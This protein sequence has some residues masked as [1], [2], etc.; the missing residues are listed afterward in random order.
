MS[1]TSSPPPQGDLR[2][3]LTQALALEYL[4]KSDQEPKEEKPL[5]L[6]L[7]ETTGFATLV[8]VLIGGL[9]GTGLTYTFQSWA[10]DREQSLANL[11]LRRD[12]DLAAFNQHLDRERK[13][14]DEM[15]QKI[16]AL[17]DGASDLADLSR[18][19]WNKPDRARDRNTIVARF[20]KAASQ[21]N[22]NRV[23]LSVLLELEH[24]SDPDLRRAFSG[25]SKSADEF[26][27][28]ADRWRA[29]FTTL[30]AREAQNGCAEFRDKLD[31]AITTFADRLV[32]LRVAA[33]KGQI[34]DE[35][36]RRIPT[37]IALLFGFL[38]ALSVVGIILLLFF[39]RFE[40]VR[41]QG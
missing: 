13:T 3:L 39:R 7:M 2:D 30:S 35:L 22:A 38:A 40:V 37:G 24:D 17:I 36:P 23:R 18:K 19:E 11:Q 9:I 12:R 8:T 27:Q 14:V 31:G 25:I 4:K 28:C 41:K 26:A 21:W 5:W 32:I 34:P 20:N 6:Q 15:A 33:A 1:T 16:G 10:K 29:M